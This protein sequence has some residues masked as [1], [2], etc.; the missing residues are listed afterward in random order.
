MQNDE[1]RR[2][3]VALE[4]SRDR[5]VD[6]YDFAPVGYLT[7]SATGLVTEANLTAATLLGVVRKELLG[8]RFDRFVA[9]A[10]RERWQRGIVSMSG[11]DGARRF[12]LALQ[13]AD[14]SPLQTH[15]DCRPA[16]AGSDGG[17]PGA[18]RVAITDIGERKRIEAALQES[19]TKYRLL[20]DN[21]A[22]CIFWVNNEGRYVYVSPAC[23]RLSGYAPEEFLADPGL[24]ARIIHPDDRAKYQAHL[25]QTRAADRSEMEFRIVRR[26]GE[27]R[28]IGHICHPMLDD[29][30]RVLG[31]R[32]SNRDI[33]ERRVAQE[34]VYKLSL[35]VEQSHESIVITDL[36]ANIE[37][38]NEAFVR[39][40]GYGLEDLIGSNQRL[41]KSGKTPRATY[42]AL[43]DALCRGQPWKGEFVNR[44]KD[45]SEY[46]EFARISPIRLAGGR[47]TH[48]LGI[49][50]DISEKKR[51][52]VELD[53]YRHHLEEVVDSRTVELAA[54]RD[55]AEAANRAKSA[56]LAN[57]SHEIR[58]PMNGILG[59]AHL[60]RRSDVTPRQ[61]E[62][63]D[64]IA[65]SG[66][67]LLGII[68]DILDLSK[69]DAGR[70]VLEQ[71]DFVL[72]DLLKNIVAVVGDAIE[73][74]GLALHIDL[75]GMPQALRGD[76]TRLGQGLV[77][78]LSNA[79]KFTERGG[80]TLCGRLI[81]EFDDTYLLRFEVA[82]T[83]VGMTAEQ[84]SRLF[85]IFEQADSS[86]TRKYG[87]TG[88]GLA[89]T[90]RIAQLMGGEVGADST[91][92]AG[93]TFWLTARL[94]K[95]EAKERAAGGAAPGEPAEA[96]LQRDYR[97]TRILLVEDDPINREVA[98]MILE[99]LGL[100]VDTAADGGEA[101]RLAQQT[102][103]ALI[104]MDVQMPEMDG[105]AATRA[106]RA[107]PGRQE[108]PILAMTANVFD[109]NRRDCLAAG[110]NDFVAKPVEIDQLF[111]VLLRWLSRR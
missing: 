1:L 69:I 50:E 45:G 19:E 36:G 26:D 61:A 20:A 12:D 91:P 5:F 110:M 10:D 79:L 25:A 53:R 18:L 104:L 28:W 4:Q 59:M 83:G 102:G 22:D 111:S 6:L 70:L 65:A 97:G 31:R 95:T 100:R 71:R 106:I 107:L 103:Y 44:R 29:A 33:T 56:F 30:G 52:G 81:E 84:C 21:A 39:H 46:T 23:L 15:I 77:N 105:L 67:H 64:K 7:L 14:G 80:I 74:K 35:A 66:R 40:S 55:A 63:L 75:A 47:I 87:G 94:G 34:Q 54:A 93:S 48:Y 92:G 49:K 42:V 88:L 108:T 43:W 101:V 17:S 76:A 13:A 32:G 68:N 24:M 109:D 73:A 72:A 99:D 3:Q 85:Q 38:A 16:A 78:Y 86:T 8:R 41:L 62:R 60:L 89:I 82:D 27:P 2:A 90:R 37:Y 96:V 51:M 11:Q 57:M 9:G 58:T 98:L